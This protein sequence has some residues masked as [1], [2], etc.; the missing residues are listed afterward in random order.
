[1][2]FEKPLRESAGASPAQ[3]DGADVQDPTR[4]S[5]DIARLRPEID[6][7]EQLSEREKYS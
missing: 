3:E 1:V 7:M 2:L 5:I 4:S 6:W